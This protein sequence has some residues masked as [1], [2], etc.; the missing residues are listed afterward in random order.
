MR[1]LLRLV[2]VEL[3]EQRD[4]HE[5]LGGV[6][7]FKAPPRLRDQLLAKAGEHDQVPQHATAVIRLGLVADFLDLIR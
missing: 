2:G 4:G 5:E 6:P 3:I 7:M 1:G